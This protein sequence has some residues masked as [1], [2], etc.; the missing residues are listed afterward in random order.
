[1]AIRHPERVSEAKEPSPW[2]SLGHYEVLAADFETD[3]ADWADVFPPE[4]AEPV[5]DFFVQELPRSGWRTVT[6][7]AWGDRP[8]NRLFAAP[9]D[10]GW[11]VVS[12]GIVPDGLP[13]FM[14][15]IGTYQLR[16]DQESRRQG[17]RLTWKDPLRV[18][19]SDLD[20][21]TVTL[22][23]TTD[24]GWTPD[25]QDH[26][27]VHGHFL[28]GNGR[29]PERCHF[30]YGGHQG[31]W[32]NASL[33]PGEALEL[34]VIFGHDD[35]PE[36]GSYGIEAILVSLNLRSPKGTITIVADPPPGTFPEKLPTELRAPLLDRLAV[37]EALQTAL[38]N[39]RAVVE[40]AAE[41]ESHA[42][43]LIAAM[44]AFDVTFA[45]AVAIGDMQVRNF[46]KEAR[47][48]LKRELRE[49]RRQLGEG[50]P[51]P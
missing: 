14:G 42:D 18:S 17:L 30:A 27:F 6:V 5:P 4:F 41:S 28:D 22:T 35:A 31:Q 2:R 21:V 43:F 40:L 7:R 23:N 48:K 32:R 33:A 3:G 44:E 20:T 8:S 25:P 11:A 46:F 50:P 26:A 15:D 10:G 47:S 12:V 24:V 9:R 34:P 16:P 45:Q 29:P 13:I 38:D 39:P 51:S 36:P 37:L 49:A 19:V 1:M